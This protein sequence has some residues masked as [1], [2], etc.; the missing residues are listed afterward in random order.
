MTTIRS[1]DQFNTTIYGL[2][3]RYRGIDGGRHVVFMN[4]ADI[5]EL[6]LSNGQVV[7]ITSHFDDGERSVAGFTVVEYKIPAGCCATYFPEANPLIPLGSHARRSFT[8][9]SKCVVV[10]IVP[11]P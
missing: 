7:N 10:S 8:P 4:K 2:D 3:D 9:T 1:H 11:S 6:G 5:A